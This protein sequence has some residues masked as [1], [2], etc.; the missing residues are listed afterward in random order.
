MSGLTRLAI[1]VFALPVIPAQLAAE[2][3]RIAGPIDAARRVTLPGNVPAKA[4]PRYDQ[5]PVDSAIRIPF[6]TL[7]MKPSAS[8]QAVLEQLLVE[9]TDRSSPN[10]HRWL[11]PEQFGDRFGLTPS[12]YA[13]VISWLQS[14]HMRIEQAARA[15]NWIAF[16]GTAGDVQLAFHTG[17]HRYLVDGES[18]IANATDVSVPAALQDIVS[19]IRGL[20]D[21]S[22]QPLD[23]TPDNTSSS[24]GHELAPG[25]WA[26]IY[27][28]SPLYAMGIDGSG[29]RIGILG[30]SD[31]NESYVNQFRT[32]FGLPAIVVE[33]HLIGAD[34]GVTNAASEAALDLEW[35]GAVAP[36]ATLVY[37]Y[38]GT[39]P[40][41]AQ[42]AIDQNL[43][44]VLNES[45]GTCEPEN[46]EGNRLM[47][48]Q[49]NAQGITW[50]ASSGDSGAADCDP[51]GFFN[52]TDNATTVSDGPAVGMPASFPEVT[53]VG[54]TEFNE[55]SGQYWSS[56]N[57]ANG[58]SALSYIPEVAWN[59]TGAGGLLA[60]GG[61]ASIYFSKPAWQVGPGVPADNARDVPDVSFSASGNHD[62]Y[63]A[64]N[65]NGTRS[66][67]TSASSPSF[68]GVVA[69]LNQ[70]LVSK[71]DLANP[72]LGN[73]NPE[74][75]RLART[76]TGVFH[77]ITQGNNMVPCVAGSSGCV[78]GLLGFS[79]GPGYDL[80]TGLG[81]IDV[82]N[83]VTQWNSPGAGT[84]TSLAASPSNIAL[85][86]S[87]QITATVTPS[88]G[89]SAVPSGVVTFTAGQTLLG[90]APL[91]SAAGIARAPLAVSGPVLPAG[92]DTVL[93]TY[94]GDSNFNSSTGSTAVTVSPGP[95]GSVVS[96]NIS[97]NPAQAGQLVTVSLTEEA[98]VSTTITGWTING[99][100]EFQLFVQDF[101]STM[102]PAYGA[103]STTIISTP[104]PG[105]RVYV[106]TGVDADGRT[107][108]QQ[109]TLI[110]EGVFQ[111]SPL[112]NVGSAADGF[113]ATLAPNSIAAAYGNNLAPA[114]QNVTTL[115]LPF[116]VEGTTLLLEDSTGN[117]TA[118]PMF[119]VSGG[120]PDQIN[121]LVPSGLASG[122]A[123]V[124][125]TNQD[126]TVSQAS[127]NIAPVSPG[128]FQLNASGL[129]AAYVVDATTNTT[130]NVYQ[131]SGGQIVPLPISIP[132]SDSVFLEIFGTGLRAA[133]EANVTVT[134][135]T[136][137]V[138]VTYSGAQGGY[139]GLDQVNVQL[140][141]S[142]AGSGD[143]V[144]Q[145][146]ANGIAA[147]PVNITIQ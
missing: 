138:P 127:T 61:G 37:I 109:Y 63:M 8:Q 33:Q 32:Q 97:P 113:I 123:T 142:L 88:V 87:T 7:T 23:V 6:I 146:T 29:E 56:T 147:N 47:A 28:V 16:S 31:L 129:A 120:A 134:I 17:I 145:L 132:A 144:V 35:S 86:G 52:V 44:T 50:V 116:M 141:S 124:I 41:A 43:A 48:Q 122:P 128:I 67:G 55:G 30:R 91:V 115:P 107:W 5:G 11:T 102:L 40:D 96:V 77:D 18:H 130:S 73:I 42:G 121:F 9:Q 79:A 92:Q 45:F 101:G 68:A 19:G 85:G 14:R 60:S 69:L 24:G 4:Q 21:F 70:Y 131:L 57:N 100:D 139:E 108:S 105:A 82:Y 12:D 136:T 39:F 22:N 58:A 93:A 143:V 38:A 114:T 66:G 81:S 112:K 98:G 95:G 74:L 10:Y 65:A 15:R 3:H 140:P 117:L 26:T 111:A 78:D 2:Q 62:P 76:T 83:L 64:V 119:Y 34:P 94:S 71:G 36:G 20:D 1:C 59:D 49:A 110:L 27:D 54:G 80:A 90:T 51:H 72:G 75:Y 99:D 84:S 89:S 53:A 133:P 103:L 106:F 25:D 118:A 135:G 137:N 13:A 125:V 46:A 104:L 126:G